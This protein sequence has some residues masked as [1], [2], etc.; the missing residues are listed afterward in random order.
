MFHR[1]STIPA[2]LAL[3]PLLALPI[4]CDEPESTD[5]AVDRITDAE[6]RVKTDLPTVSELRAELGADAPVGDRPAAAVSLEMDALLGAGEAVSMPIFAL[7]EVEDPDKVIAKRARQLG[8]EFGSFEQDPGSRRLSAVDGDWSLTYNPDNGAEF[9]VDRAHFHKSTPTQEVLSEREYVDIARDFVDNLE[10]G[11]VGEGLS[12]YRVRWY[13]QAGAAQDAPAP[14]D[15]EVYQV[16][17]AF[18]QSYGD[19]P[20]IGAGGKIA[21]HLSPDGDLLAYEN[22][23]RAS[24]KVLAEVRRDHLISPR[25]AESQVRERLERAGIDLSNYDL[26]RQEL[27]YERLGRNGVQSLVAPAHAFFFTPKDG[28]SS[29]ILIELE[30]AVIAGPMRE[31]MDADRAREIERKARRA[32]FA[33]ELSQR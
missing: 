30:P 24:T 29:K 22:T 12:V 10:L 21:V 9:L 31:A 11:E 17:I 5:S 6:R 28:V 15:G 32:A 16:A 20:V 18:N 1:I 27:G 23:L 26:S 3:L 33:G 4:A 14:L 7:A 19:L 25:E 13:K 8:R 2:L